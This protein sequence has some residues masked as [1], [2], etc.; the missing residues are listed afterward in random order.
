M[1]FAVRRRNVDKEH[2]A[3]LNAAIAR[4]AEIATRLLSARLEKTTQILL[5]ATTDGRRLFENAQ[6]ADAL[7]AAAK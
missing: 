2:R 3:I 7:L 4:D 5:D 6:D 1:P